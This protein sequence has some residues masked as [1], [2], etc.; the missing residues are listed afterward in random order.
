MLWHRNLNISGF[1]NRRDDATC[2]LTLRIDGTSMGKYSKQ[3]VRADVGRLLLH[4]EAEN[5]FW[6]NS[7]HFFEVNEA[8]LAF[9]G[10]YLYLLS[11]EDLWRQHHALI[12]KLRSTLSD[13]T[14]FDE[15][16]LHV[17]DDGR[18]SEHHATAK[19]RQAIVQ[20]LAEN[21]P[22]NPDR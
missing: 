10:L 1:R 15:L 19:W 3:S 21:G 2:I 12:K 9:E 11:R 4:C 13:F 7:R 8:E 18:D 16:E 22:N 14:D 17:I 20:E 6:P 5:D